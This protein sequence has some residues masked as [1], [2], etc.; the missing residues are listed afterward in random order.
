VTD[1]ID[2]MEST[3]ATFEVL[4]KPMVEKYEAM[5]KEVAQK[6]GKVYLDP[7]DD[8]YWKIQEAYRK[9][10]HALRKSLSEGEK[11]KR[12]SAIRQAEAEAKGENAKIVVQ[13]TERCP[14]CLGPM[15]KKAGRGRP[16]KTCLACRGLA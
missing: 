5:Q 7:N 3:F 6:L 1:T 14:Q 2:A 15:T 12:K 13:K 16:P 4:H 11:A 10:Y 9:E 8:G